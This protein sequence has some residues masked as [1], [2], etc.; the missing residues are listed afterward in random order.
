[1]LSAREHSSAQAREKLKAAGY[2]DAVVDATLQ[3]AVELRFIDDARYADALIRSRIA[4]GKGIAFALRDIEALGID[5]FE[6][7]S[8]LE[9]QEGG[10]E[11]EVSRALALLDRRP[12]RCKNAR[13]GAYRKLMQ[14]GFP[15]S[16]ASQASRQWTER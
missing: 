15:P 3:R 8:Y 13:E 1:M 10:E 9:H 12:P 11:S 6:L 5:P 2:S 4:A 7:D 14:A 16:I